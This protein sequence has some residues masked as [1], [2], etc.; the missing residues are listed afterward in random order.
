MKQTPLTDSDYAF[1]ER[2]RVMIAPY[3]PAKQKVIVR[4]LSAVA[5][6]YVELYELEEAEKKA[7]EGSDH[8]PA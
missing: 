1:L 5:K 3:S 6:A 8:E 4:A 2:I 7:Q